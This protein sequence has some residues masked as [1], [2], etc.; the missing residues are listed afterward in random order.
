[1]SSKKSGFAWERSLLAD[2]QVDS[3]WLKLAEAFMASKWTK[4][5]FEIMR[6]L[7][8]VKGSCEAS[9]DEEDKVEDDA[10]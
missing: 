10:K 4:E 1:M 3:A 9:C 2:D 5:E 7:L 6:D 8:C